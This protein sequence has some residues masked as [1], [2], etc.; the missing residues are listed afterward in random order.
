ME[1]RFY[2]GLFLLAVLL[3]LGLLTGWAA[4]RSLA[5]VVEDLNR[6]TQALLNGDFTAGARLARQAKV[7]W[8]NRWRYMAAIADHAPMDEIDGL[9]SQAEY[10]VNAFDNTRL[11]ACCARLGELVEAIADAHRLNWW[12]I[13]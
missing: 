1:K 9:F 8:Q 6:A 4:N 13:L 12:N 3:V 10:Y 7:T 2:L 5:P 11:G